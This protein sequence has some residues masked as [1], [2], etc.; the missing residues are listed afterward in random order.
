MPTSSPLYQDRC[1]AGRALAR[2]LSAYADRPDVLVLALPRG[3]VPVAVEVA[4][5]LKAPLDV[6]VARK[7]GAPGQPEFAIGA[8]AAGAR[9]VNQR[10]VQLLRIDA[11]ALERL[12]ETEQAELERR[13]R[14]YRPGRPPIDARGACVVAVDDGLATGE[15]LGVA[16]RALRRMAPGR[17]VAAVP[18]GAESSVR[19]L[20]GQADEVVC[21]ATPHPFKSVGQWYRD[22]TQTTDDDVRELLAPVHAKGKPA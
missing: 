20:R 12:I 21:A 16:L 19:D 18:V 6:F 13:E 9:H 7:L 2:R 22:F 15:T 4:R 17:L 14:L 10:M 1:D 5:A 11:A 3:G 8:I